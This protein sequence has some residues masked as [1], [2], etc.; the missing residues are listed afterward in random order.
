M[1]ITIVGSDS[2]IAKHLIHSLIEKKENLNLYGRKH[3][4]FYNE[5]VVDNFFKI[6][7]NEFE[8]SKF[9]I[10]FAAI[11]HQLSQK[12]TELYRKINTELPIYL[13]KEAKK[14][15]VSNF[16][17]LSS[18]AVYGQTNHIDENSIEKPETIYGKSKLEAD[19][20]LLNLQDS[21]FKVTIIRP[22]MVYGG[23]NAPGNM[24]N[25]IRFARKGVPLPFKNVNNKRDFIH[26]KNLVNAI[27][28]IHKYD[29]TG[30][31]HPTDKNSVSTDAI[32]GLIKKY[33]SKKVRYFT[34]PEIFK[35]LLRKINPQIYNK[36]FGSL[37]VSC[38]LPTKLYSPPYRF[39][40]GIKEMLD[41][42]ESK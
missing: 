12:N 26:V 33:S 37:T 10:N 18:I 4:D 34:V 14:A 9:V 6:T 30:I 3:S 29:I 19:K 2:F 41:Y 25:L 1:S 27:E 7:S 38:N 42:L 36:L 16:V 39:D 40:E 21:N 13:A 15:G 8:G 11:V 22:P 31:L 35:S 17:Q 20:K 28:V 32:L 5:H 24:I 23:G